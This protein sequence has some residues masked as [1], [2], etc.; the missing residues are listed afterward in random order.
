[1]ALPACVRDSSGGLPLDAVCCQSGPP[2]VLIASPSPPPIYFVI[3]LRFEHFRVMNVIAAEVTAQ[4][5]HTTMK[6]FTIDAENNITIYDSKKAARE[7]GAGVF[8][9]EVQLA[10]LIGPDNNRLV[11]IYNGLPGVKP[12]AKFANRKIATE[13]IWKAIQTLGDGAPSGEATAGAEPQAP[14]AEQPAATAAAEPP[15][16]TVEEPIAELHPEAPIAPTPAEP[17]A[18]VG[19]QAAEVAP[20]QP[21]PAN[22]TAHIKKA[23]KAKKAAKEAVAADGAKTE[24]RGPREGSKTAQVVAMLQREHGA[25]ISEIMSTMSWQKH[26]VRGFMA[27][28]MKK[29]G[30][31]GRILQARGRRTHLSH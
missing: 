4:G 21:T 25:T 17:L 23:R 12:V 2:A 26:T 18:D 22:G 30:L 19:A 10:G 6:H 27:G 13:R 9:N 3:A 11:E 5:D 20:E 31:R 14:P 15:A 8:A 1:M 16:V 7:T 24:A 29:A 28:A